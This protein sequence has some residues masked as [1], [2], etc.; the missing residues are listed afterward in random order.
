MLN[1]GWTTKG[2]FEEGLRKFSVR[3]RGEKEIEGG[4]VNFRFGK[5]RYF[6]F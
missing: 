2:Y 3:Q 1:I 5:W 4:G 6:H